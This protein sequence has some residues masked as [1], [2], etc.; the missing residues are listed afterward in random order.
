MP[1][2]RGAHP[3]TIQRKIVAPFTALVV[4]VMGLSAA[5]SIVL[6]NR[7]ADRTIY[8]RLSRSLEAAAYLEFTSLENVRQV[9]GVDFAGTTAEGMMRTTPMAMDFDAYQELSAAILLAVNRPDE[10]SA[11][12]LA[13]RPY[14]ALHRRLDVEEP[15]LILTAFTPSDDIEQTKRGVA[16][17]IG[18]VTAAGILLA[19]FIGNRIARTI[20]TPLQ[21]LVAVTRRVADG[22]WSR[23]AEVRSQDETGRLAAAFN[24]MTA[25]L[26]RTRQELVQAERLATAGQMSAT[27]AHEIRNPLSSMKMMMQLAQEQTRDEKLSRFLEN[28]L[29]EIDR[30]DNLVEEMLDFSR[31]AQYRFAPCDLRRTL[32]SVL[33]LVS[34]NFL[35]QRIA[36]RFDPSDVP[37]ISA[38]EDAMKRALL[39]VLLNAAQAQPQGGEVRV[40][41]AAED[42]KARIEISDNGKGFSQDALNELFRPFFTTKTRGSGLGLATT[43]RI[44]EGHGGEIHVENLPDGGAKVTLLLPYR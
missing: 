43:K 36:V 28:T 23:R 34:P 24:E 2:R 41:L 15:Y 35:R 38:D 37:V 27:F 17:A 22:D 31:P 4:V 29:E 30:L 6:F 44:L 13:G 7:Y 33:E 12:T 5:T 32:E 3:W 9:L 20:T 25:Q 42:A 18:G 16:M 26:L 39:N 40:R 11:F 8:D 1:H 14:R 10:M 19:L 21:E